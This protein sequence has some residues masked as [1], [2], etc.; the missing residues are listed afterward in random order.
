MDGAVDLER[1]LATLHPACFG[2]AMACCR[3]DR[4]SACDV[5]QEAYCR[6]LDGRARWGGE[7]VFKT[8]LF[9]VIRL[10]AVEQRRW[11]VVR[12]LRA[13]APADP[14]TGPASQRAPDSDLGARE[15]GRAL[16]E[17]LARL[18]DRQREVLHLV[19]Y[20][21]LSLRDAAA[22]MGVSLGTASQHYDRGK[23]ALAAQLGKGTTGR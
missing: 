2:W 23:A 3:R 12:W 11:A 5:L 15:R 17:A 22:A 13:S 10:V 14:T 6:V 19:F 20:E 21:E 4:D 16:S 9:A 18:P 7:G 1:E 8:W